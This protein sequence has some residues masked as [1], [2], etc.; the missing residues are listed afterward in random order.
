[1]CRLSRPGP[2]HVEQLQA[3]GAAS[4]DARSASR[5]PA[6]PRSATSIGAASSTSLMPSLSR[7]SCR[8]SR[9]T[10]SRE[11][12]P[13]A[14]RSLGEP[15]AQG[16]GRGGRRLAR[17]PSGRAARAWRGGRAASRNRRPSCSSERL[18]LQVLPLRPRPAS[19]RR[20]HARAASASTSASDPVRRQDH[21]RQRPA[22]CRRGARAGAGA[23]GASLSG[24][25]NSAWIARPSLRTNTN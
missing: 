5:A 16:L 24:S 25:T 19:A 17:G 18:R 15:R 14:L 4:P 23:G 1:M 20:P 9:A 22:A 2:V 3:P 12:L 11:C 10:S 6:R 8:A 13:R 21:L 7:C